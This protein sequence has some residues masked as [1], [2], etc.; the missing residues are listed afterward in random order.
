MS[1]INFAFIIVTIMFF[2]SCSDDSGPGY[3]EKKWEEKEV[4]QNVFRVVHDVGRETEAARDLPEEGGDPARGGPQI[5]VRAFT[6]GVR[7]RVFP[8]PSR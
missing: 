4:E 2:F 8:L 3:Q 1:K 6:Y 7:K 5:G